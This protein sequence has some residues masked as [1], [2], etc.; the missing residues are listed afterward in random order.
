[1]LACSVA[2][3]MA[4]AVGASNWPGRVGP[5]PAASWRRRAA[6]M[7]ARAPCLASTGVSRRQTNPASRTTG[8][9]ESQPIPDPGP[10]ATDEMNS[11]R[12]LSNV[13][14]QP[15]QQKRSVYNLLRRCAS[16]AGAANRFLTKRG[17]RRCDECGLQSRCL[18]N[19]WHQLRN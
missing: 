4:R 6:R 5:S 8:L 2:R 18:L 1:M 10:K 12:Q 17:K 15:T 3:L 11:V 7:P 13:N 16:T 19:S 9:R 14:H